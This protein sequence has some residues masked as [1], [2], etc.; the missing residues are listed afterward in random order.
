MEARVRERFPPPTPLKHLEDV[1]EDKWH[2]LL[3]QTVQNFYESILRRIAALL[4]AEGGPMP[5]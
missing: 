1:L 3:L 2:K 4:K 5:C